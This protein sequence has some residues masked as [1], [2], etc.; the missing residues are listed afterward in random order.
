MEHRNSDAPLVFGISPN[1]R[2]K[3]SN[4]THKADDKKNFVITATS[5][6]NSPVKDSTTP[7]LANGSK[8][9][10]PFKITPIDKGPVKPQKIGLK[11]LCYN[12]FM[13][14]PPVSQRGNDY[15]DERMIEV[16]PKLQAYDICC[17]Q[18]LFSKANKRRHKICKAAV[19]FG[20]KYSTYVKPPSNT[21]KFKFPIIDSGLVILSRFPIIDSDFKRFQ[22]AWGWDRF[23]DKG[24][25]YAKI[26]ITQRFIIHVFNTHPQAG[27]GDWPEAV[28]IKETDPVRYEKI[29]TTYLVRMDQV[30][31]MRRFIEEKVAKAD[32]ESGNDGMKSLVVIMGNIFF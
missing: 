16:I 12:L 11:L 6:S 15:K 18:E 2:V 27:Y 25:L 3:D 20:L 8:T 29:I 1:L 22:S 9:V 32:A 4:K 30:C 5:R 23:A 17:F 19:D 26:L 13:R 21:L 7:I 14:P 10:S 24:C 28:K 31:E